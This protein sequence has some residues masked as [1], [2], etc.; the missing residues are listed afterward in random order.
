[1]QNKTMAF[2]YP[3]P[4]LRLSSITDFNPSVVH[5]FSYSGLGDL[6]S[7]S[8]DANGYQQGKIHLAYA[9][10]RVICDSEQFI[11]AHGYSNSVPDCSAS[12]GGQ[13]QM[14]YDATGKLISMTSP[15]LYTVGPITYSTT[16]TAYS[17]SFQFGGYFQY[18]TNQKLTRAANHRDEGVTITR[19]STIDTFQ[20][21][22]GRITRL[23]ERTLSMS[24]I[25]K[26]G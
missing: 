5:R 4:L 7:V 2:S 9:D 12:G 22:L 15:D 21:S 18:D 6:E 1:V 19:T 8:V 20:D 17:D 26:I 13:Y 11:D 25:R 16:Q 3:S 24:T 14:E 23:S 10:H